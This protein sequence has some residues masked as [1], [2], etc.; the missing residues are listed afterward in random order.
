MHSEVWNAKSNEE[1]E[2][3]KEVIVESIDGLVLQVKPKKE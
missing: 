1:L 2:K 3:G